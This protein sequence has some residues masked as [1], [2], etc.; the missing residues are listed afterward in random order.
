M[1]SRGT[2]R[3]M[4]GLQRGAFARDQEDMWKLLPEKSGPLGRPLGRALTPDFN[5]PAGP[6]PSQFPG[7]LK[8]RSTRLEFE[9]LS[10]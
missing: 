3:Y 1:T 6:G 7:Y 5:N 9:T 2:D 4:M 8:W 10:K